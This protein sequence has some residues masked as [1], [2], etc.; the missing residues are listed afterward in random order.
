[1]AKRRHKVKPMTITSKFNRLA[2]GL[3]FFGAQIEEKKRATKKQLK[4]LQKF[5]RHLRKQLK[6]DQPD[7]ELPSIAQAAK[8][9]REQE[10][11]PVREPETREALPYSEATD[12]TP[13]IDFSSNVLDDFLDTLQEAMNELVVTYGQSP[14][15]LDTMTKQHSDII[16]TFN[17]LKETIG[18]ENLATH[19]TQSLEYEALGTI[20]KYSYN[21][22]IEV[23]DNILTN[24][25][26]ILNQANDYY[27]SPQT[28]ANGINFDNL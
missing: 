25:Q 16:T 24:L 5:Y 6:Q 10:T 19:I 7:I 21:G 4:E 14:R 3:Q 26:G 28:F 15:I 11:Q 2:K 1:M 13:Q 18:E 12:E 23:L 9:V 17:T 8:Y 27:N 20:T 22:V